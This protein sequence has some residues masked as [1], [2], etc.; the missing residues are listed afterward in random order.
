MP[1]RREVEY[2][3][4]EV[5]RGVRDHRRRY[6]GLPEGEVLDVY[7]VAFHGQVASYGYTTLGVRRIVSQGPGPKQ[8]DAPLTAPLHRNPVG[9]MQENANTWSNGR[10]RIQAHANGALTIDD[11]KSG[12]T[13]ANVLLL[14]DEADIGDGWT[15]APTVTNEVYSSVDAQAQVSVVYGGPLQT[16]I[17]I[18]MV[19]RVPDRALAN[20][21]RRSETLVNL[22]VT[23]FVELTQGDPVIRRRTL[24]R[25]AARDHRLRVLFPTGLA[26]DRYHTSTPFDLVERPIARPDL[27]N[28][29]QLDNGGTAQSLRSRP[30]ARHKR[31]WNRFA[32]RWRGITSG[33]GVCNANSTGSG[34]RT[35]RSA[36][37]NKGAPSI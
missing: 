35:I 13:Y 5:T 11:L 32:S 34:G 36:T 28:H 15:S 10:V 21:T 31:R 6:R 22:P 37:T 1:H 23:T 4:L 18:Q 7:R 2:Q 12:A 17:R 9:S 30:L 27:R 24:V 14:E 26:T 29:L 33:F 25:N 19:M 3:L 20:Q 16:C 8:Y